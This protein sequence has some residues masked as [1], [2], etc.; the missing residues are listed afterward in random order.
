MSLFFATFVLA[1]SLTTPLNDLGKNE[2]A[3]GLYG[4]LWPDGSNTM[5]AAHFA[6]GQRH[7]AKITPR[8]ASGRPDAHG[9]IVFLAVGGQN[10]ALTFE[11]MKEKLAG[12]KSVAPSVVMLSA[13]FPGA[14]A[15]KWALPWNGTYARVK[16]SVL[17]PA[18]VSEQQV[19]A[20]W[21]QL[22]TDF[23][24]PSLPIQN[25]DAYVVKGWIAEAARQLKAHYPNLEV[26]YLSSREYGGYAM[27]SQ[28]P[29]PFGY[30]TA[31]AVRWVLLGQIEYMRTGSWWDTRTGNLDA[32]TNAPWLTWGPYPWAN[33]AEARNDGL[34]WYRDDFGPTGDVFSAKGAD[35]SAT[36]L[37]NFLMREPSAAWF[38]SNSAA[39]IPGRS[40]A[41]RR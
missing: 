9:K 14:D 41:V 40:R 37:M 7:S 2:I 20:V 32:E 39:P 28:H 1:S 16:N 8:D 24:Y 17:T 3:W 31:I 5:P 11:R 34:A 29:E 12:T 6:A 18:G 36:L 10:T 27:T 25:A 21:L 22:S 23:P 4:G 19:Q 13:S 38:R 35:K 15:E 30:E 26:A 33:G